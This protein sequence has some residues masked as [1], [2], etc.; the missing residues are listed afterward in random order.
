[1][2]ST[3]LDRV[4]DWAQRPGYPAVVQLLGGE[5]TLHPRIL[6]FV[7]TLQQRGV[8]IDTIFTNGLGE[9]YVY[10]EI[11]KISKTGW[12]VN[13][14][15][16]DSYTAEEWGL[17]NRNLEVLR[18]KGNNTMKAEGFDK[19]VFRLQIGMTF[20][21][22]R[23]EYSYIIELG[24]KYGC[25]YIRCDASRPGK[26]KCNKYVD[27]EH[28]AGLKPTLLSFFKDCVREGMRPVL[29]EAIPPCIFTQKELTYV[30]LFVDG[31][32][33]VCAPNS[34]VFPDLT[35]E[36]CAPMRGILPAYSINEYKFGEILAEHFRNAEPFK[37]VALPR[38]K[39]CHFFSKGQCQ[40]YCLQYKNDFLEKSSYVQMDQV[41]PA[42]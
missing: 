14:D 2:T 23:Q 32:R 5:P 6:D 27:F 4:I 1:M 21:K 41:I 9:T 10:E 38:C 37:K 20:Y 29:D 40:G 18:W 3:D 26:G 25:A 31:F 17:L 30:T 13:I 34:D 12:L 33:S 35:V 24:K 28:L 16:P 36:H 42:P 22:P 7:K 11:T 15:N 8:A 39:G 19:D